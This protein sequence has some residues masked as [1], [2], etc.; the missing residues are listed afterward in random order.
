MI[1]VAQSKGMSMI[2]LKPKWK[3]QK[4][5]GKPKLPV[6]IPTCFVKCEV[7]LSVIVT[8]TPSLYRNRAS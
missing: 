4:Y 5:T 2:N 3:K 7:M 1:A 6:T 8:A